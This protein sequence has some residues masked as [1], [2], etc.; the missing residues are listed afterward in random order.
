MSNNNRRRPVGRFQF[1]LI[2]GIFFVAMDLGVVFTAV[3]MESGG[4]IFW[5]FVGW[6]VFYGVAILCWLDDKR[7]D[8]FERVMGFVFFAMA[9]L[10]AIAMAIGG[11]WMLVPKITAGEEVLGNL[12]ALIIVEASSVMFAVIFYKFFLKDYIKDLMGKHRE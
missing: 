6:T 4:W 12:F 11:L 9:F 5:F 7:R 2:L 3:F 8:L 10:L 1:N